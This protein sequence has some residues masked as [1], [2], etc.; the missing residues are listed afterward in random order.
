MHEANANHVPTIIRIIKPIAS[1]LLELIHDHHEER[2]ALLFGKSDAN[3]ILF[4][5]IAEAENLRHSSSQFEIDP[6]FAWQKISENEGVYG[7]NLAIGIFHTHPRGY[8]APSQRDI[9][10]MRNW[11]VPWLI[12]SS[13]DN[14]TIKAYIFLQ[15][16]PREIPIC[17]VDA[18]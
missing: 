16:K 1:R 5:S 10:Y 2:C 11:D 4:D 3:S 14:P 7:E 9:D 8:F 6:E 18:D 12:G 15:N 13:N 17:L